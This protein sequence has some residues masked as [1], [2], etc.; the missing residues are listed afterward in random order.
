MVRRG[1]Q[2]SGGRGEPLPSAGRRPILTPLSGGTR[3][4]ARRRPTHRAPGA[5][6]G[7]TCR[8]Q[9]R[10]GDGRGERTGCRACTPARA[11]RCLRT[12]SRRARGLRRG[13]GVRDPRRWRRRPVP[14]SRCGRVGEWSAA[15]E[16]AL[17][18][19]GRIDVLV[20][21]A[22]IIRL[23]DFVAETIEG[24]NDVIR[25]D[26]FGVFFGM[27]HV[28]PRHARTTVGLDHQHL[29]EHGDRR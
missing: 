6:D 7:R 12:V 16:A 13:R 5:V 26:Q 9:D 10:A 22:G 3:A 29:L 4:R 11:R 25:V 21:N 15:V 24:W 28:H 14:T 27:K 8:G 2:E 23:E 18:R 17:E 20:N 1:R 19:W